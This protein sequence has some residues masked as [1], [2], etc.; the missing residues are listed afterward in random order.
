MTTTMTTTTTTIMGSRVITIP[1]RTR[2]IR[3]DR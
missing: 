2:T 1:T 3:W